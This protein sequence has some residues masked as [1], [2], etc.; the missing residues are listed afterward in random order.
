MVKRGFN[1]LL[2]FSSFL[3]PLSFFL[4]LWPSMSLFSS[5]FHPFLLDSTLLCGLLLFSQGGKYFGLPTFFFVLL[6]FFPSLVH[7]IFLMFILLPCVDWEQK[8][9]NAICLFHYGNKRGAYLLEL[10]GVI[11]FMLFNFIG[12]LKVGEQE[13]RAW[14]KQ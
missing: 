6:F 5:F 4:F 3:L 12:M 7:L 9:I 8:E 10:F 14:C 1:Y 13:V 11:C 2:P